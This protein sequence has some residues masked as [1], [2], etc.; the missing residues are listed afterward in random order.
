MKKIVFLVSLTLVTLS[1]FAAPVITGKSRIAL[2]E[3]GQSDKYVLFVLS[4]D[5]SDGYDNTYDAASANPG[6]GIYVLVND[7]EYTS[8]ASNKYS[9]N[10]ALGFVATK[11]GTHT[12]K[13][14]KFDGAEYKIY[15]RVA[16]K[17]ITVN[18]STSS[19]E[20]TVDAA[21]TYNSRFVINYNPN[22]L[23]VCFIDN[24]LEISSNPFDAPIK[25]IG[26]NGSKEVAVAPTPQNISLNDS[27]AGN[28]TVEF[29]GGARKF[30]VVVKH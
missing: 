21:G 17:T 6:T 24:V 27:V 11:S 23:A 3:E 19:Y 16:D 9:A 5:F 29:N 7:D 12:L 25:I 14:D 4:D 18:G 20:F 1:M 15:D 2:Q 13:F 22:N 26:A 8:W 10:L 30:V 28:Y